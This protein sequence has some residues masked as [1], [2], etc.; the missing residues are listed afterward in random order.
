MNLTPA[1]AKARRQVELDDG[2]VGYLLFVPS[3][4]RRRGQTGRR[5]HGGPGNRIRVALETGAV[6]SCDPEQV[7]RAD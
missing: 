6:I 4:G 5:D 7:R 1:D 3:G 2:R